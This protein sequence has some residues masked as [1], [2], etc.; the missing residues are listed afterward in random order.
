MRAILA[1]AVLLVPAPAFAQ[2]HE[3]HQGHSMAEPAG[4]DPHVGHAM[5]A[6]EEPDPHAGHAM[7]MAETEE[8]D[9]HTGHTMPDADVHA[10]HGAMEEG[11]AL[12]QSGPPPEAFSGPAHA[13]DT[14][15]PPAVMAEAR[16]ELRPITGGATHH[17]FS[18]DR[19]EAQIADGEDGYLWE[20]NAWVGG[21]T[22]K[23]WIKSEG[24]GESGGTL[25]DA[26][27]QA[28]WS[29][30]IA[31]FF[32]LQ[33]GVRYDLRPE[34]DRAHIV[35]GIQGLAPYF[36]EIDA[37][38][39]LS[40]EGDLT[41]RIEAEYDQR[42]TQRLI[43]QPRVELGFSAQDI[44]E[45]G[46]GAGLSA[47]EAGLRLRYEFSPRFAPYLGVEW[48]QR[49][50]YTADYARAAGENPGRIVFLTGVRLWF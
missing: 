1:A 39:F 43:L 35:L 21:D 11:N 10:G 30:A 22:D 42:I 13:A 50:G 12:P 36:F 27:V 15:F 31:P 44:P 47:L 40:N 7:P 14:I 17:L 46:I 26:E 34:P 20:V 6:G 18:I 16:A 41:A 32:D 29:H 37:A 38:A 49:I 45:I 33:T 25:E 28:L 2:D 19:L 5:P 3:T 8:A 9:P 23:L 24:E 4:A 48:Q